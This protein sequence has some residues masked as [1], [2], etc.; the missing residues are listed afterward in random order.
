MSAGGDSRQVDALAR[1]GD[2][3]GTGLQMLDDLGSLVSERRA[4]KGR[5]DLR[6]LPLVTIDGEVIRATETGEMFVRN[7]ALCF[8]R[9]WREKHSTDDSPKFSRSV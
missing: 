6:Q 5:E 8:D 2:R 4:S 7:L 3:L 1:F 9:Y